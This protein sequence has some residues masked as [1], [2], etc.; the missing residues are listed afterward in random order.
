MTGYTKICHTNG[1]KNSILKQD[2]IKMS[3]FSSEEYSVIWMIHPRLKHSHIT[4][5]NDSK[6]ALRALNSLL[7]ILRIVQEYG[8]WNMELLWVLGHY[9]IRRNGTSIALP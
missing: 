7:F 4:T 9:D 3:A 8:I 5:C 1:S 2:K 6:T